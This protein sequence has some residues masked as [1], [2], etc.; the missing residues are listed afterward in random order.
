MFHAEETN[1]GKGASC[2]N[3]NQIK[4]FL[5]ARIIEELNHP[6]TIYSINNCYDKVRLVSN[7]NSTNINVN[8]GSH[9]FLTT[10]K[11]QGHK[12]DE[13]CF[14]YFRMSN[15]Y[16]ANTFQSNFFRNLKQFEEYKLLNIPANTQSGLPE[17][18]LPFTPH[19]FAHIHGF[20][21]DKVY[22][23]RYICDSIY[24]N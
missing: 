3:E 10:L 17:V 9:Q 15:S 14:D 13:I 20:H 19:F 4:D 12:F 6:C 1:I 22:V 7:Q 11:N 2:L 8:A 21:F 5:R 23:I 24:H 18:Y 16:T